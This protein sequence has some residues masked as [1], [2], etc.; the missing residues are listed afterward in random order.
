M[1]TIITN[2]L[3]GLVFAQIAWRGSNSVSPQVI[4]GLMLA[5]VLVGVVF[6]LLLNMLPHETLWYALGDYVH[7][8]VAPIAVPM[9]WAAFARHGVLRWTSPLLWA[10]Y[11]LA[12]SV[13]AV[14]RAQFMPP[15]TGMHSRYPYFFMDADLLG[16]PMAITGMAAI[17]LGFV[18]TGM[19]AVACDKWLAS[20]T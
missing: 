1:F 5:I 10:C 11:P 3:V 2:L 20:R 12:Y 9:W 4:G 8:V 13:Y 16:W 19:V 7:H 6:N 14:V 15:G 17:A 18:L